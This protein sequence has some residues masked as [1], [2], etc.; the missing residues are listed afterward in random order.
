MDPQRDLCKGRGDALA[1]LLK[2][3]LEDLG[4]KQHLTLR[5]QESSKS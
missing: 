2:A 3:T 4:E 5:K 1:E